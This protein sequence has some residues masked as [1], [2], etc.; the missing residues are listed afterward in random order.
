VSHLQGQTTA[1]LVSPPRRL[2]CGAALFFRFFARKTSP[3]G[4]RHA[5]GCAIIS[6]LMSRAGVLR[7]KGSIKRFQEQILKEGACARPR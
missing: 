1:L 3:E 4:R 5:A 7:G 2:S 6:P